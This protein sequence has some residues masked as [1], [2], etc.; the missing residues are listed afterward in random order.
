MPNLQNIYDDFSAS[1]GANR[2]L[3]QYCLSPTGPHTQAGIEAAFLQL[4]KSWELFLENLLLCLLIGHRPH[5]TIITSHFT[6]SDLEIARGIVLREDN[7]LDWIGIDRVKNRFNAYLIEAPNHISNTLSAIATELNEIRIV[8]N[9][10][11]HSSK[12]AKD[13]FANLWLRKVGGSPTITV[14]ADFLKLPDPNNLPST[15]FD[16]YADTLETAAGIM[17]N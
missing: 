7:Y 13:D 1:L 5:T 9:A 15:Y 3:F 14:P 2:A 10:I 16:K 6:V 12:K 4:Q 11:A 17:I 8:R